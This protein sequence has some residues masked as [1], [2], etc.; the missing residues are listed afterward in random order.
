MPEHE[1]ANTWVTIFNAPDGGWGIAGRAYTGD[2]L[3]AEITAAAQRQPAATGMTTT[4]L[5]GRRVAFLVANDGVED[6]ELTHPWDAVTAA[7]GRAVLI[8]PRR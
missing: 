5:S 6:I 1:P 3:V 2:D 7:G 4:D 8:A